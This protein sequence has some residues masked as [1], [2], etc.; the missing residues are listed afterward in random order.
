MSDGLH[1]NVNEAAALALLLVAR[2][3]EDVEWWL[4]WEDLPNLDEY[5]I[6]LVADQMTDVA[7]LVRSHLDLFEN[8]SDIDSRDLLSRATA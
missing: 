3:I 1:L 7:R 6:G 2:R 5:S 4:D 8:E